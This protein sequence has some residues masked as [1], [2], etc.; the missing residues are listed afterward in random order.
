MKSKLMGAYCNDDLNMPVYSAGAPTNELRFSKHVYDNVHGNIYLDPV[1]LLFY[2][3]PF[4]SFQIVRLRDKEEEAPE[5]LSVMLTRS[6]N[7]F[8]WRFSAES[9]VPFVRVGILMIDSL[10]VDL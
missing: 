6:V 2:L 9:A 5:L 3:S 10:V 1:I 4:P 8:L 7:C